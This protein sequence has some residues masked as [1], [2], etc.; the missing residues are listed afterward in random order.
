MF[1]MPLLGKDG[2]PSTTR[3]FCLEGDIYG[4]T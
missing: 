4:G 2:Y 1:T 3:A